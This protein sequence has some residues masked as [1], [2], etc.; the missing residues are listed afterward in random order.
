MLALW[1]SWVK[2]YFLTSSEL[3]LYCFHTIDITQTRTV[4]LTRR[5]TKRKIISSSL[6]YILASLI[7]CSTSLTSFAR[8]RDSRQSIRWQGLQW[9][10]LPSIDLLSGEKSKNDLTIRHRVHIF[11]NIYYYFSMYNFLFIWLIVQDESI[12]IMSLNFF[13][14]ISIHNSGDK[15]VQD[16][17]ISTS[18]SSISSSERPMRVMIGSSLCLGVPI[19]QK[20]SHH[21]SI[22]LLSSLS[23]SNVSI[24]IGIVYKLYADYHFRRKH[25]LVKIITTNT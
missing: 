16:W 18:N 6:S 19:F 22:S 14:Y 2:T 8:L 10:A 3:S 20:S 17:M 15:S 9:Q 25:S 13:Q 11:E 5:T 1:E 4:T 21:W 7:S 23:N 24:S 12:S